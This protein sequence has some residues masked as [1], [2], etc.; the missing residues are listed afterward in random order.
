M[1]P[2]PSGLAGLNEFMRNSAANPTPG[3][4][5]PPPQGAGQQPATV[6]EGG[7]YSF[8]QLVELGK[9]AQ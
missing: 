7:H 9:K 3:P 6:P 8:E 4:I 2:P 5:L 1:Q